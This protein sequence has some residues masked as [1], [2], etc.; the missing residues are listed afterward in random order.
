MGDLHLSTVTYLTSHTQD[1]FQMLESP[2]ISP[3]S[4]ALAA[5]AQT[6]LERYVQVQSADLSLLLRKSVEAR[7]W[8]S[9]VEP[10]SVRAVMKRVV[11][12]VTIID[13]QVGQLYE[14][15]QRKVR[16]SDSSRTFGGHHRSRSVF[17]SYNSSNLD[18]SL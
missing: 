6:L 15:G 1:E 9:T 18:S 14:E 12:D 10:R 2:N 16:S 17:S 7:D 5:T 8:L 4:L 3:V 11:E 13:E